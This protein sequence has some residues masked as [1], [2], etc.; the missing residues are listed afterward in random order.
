MTARGGLDWDLA[1]DVPDKVREEVAECAETPAEDASQQ[2]R[3]HDHFHPQ[4]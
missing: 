4:G 1:R 2:A 3:V